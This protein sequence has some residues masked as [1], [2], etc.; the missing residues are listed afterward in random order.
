[1][2]LLKIPILSPKV[3][4]SMNTFTSLLPS[5]FLLWKR[6]KP[7]SLF[8][9]Q[10]KR[11]CDLFNFQMLTLTSPP[12]PSPLLPHHHTHK[13]RESI[14]CTRTPW[15][16]FVW[17]QLL[18]LLPKIP[19]SAAL[20][21]IGKM[22]WGVGILTYSFKKV[23]CSTLLPDEKFLTVYMNSM[24]N[25]KYLGTSFRKSDTAQARERES[26][27]VRERTCKTFIFTLEL[28]RGQNYS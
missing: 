27:R 10:C 6:N 14:Q 26:T 3:L 12:P 13:S 28:E 24:R 21:R 17:N 9:H 16:H 18:S 5:D 2:H 15:Q 7:C 1:M 8:N 4:C 20:N 11:T 23:N 25:K 19:C 22:G